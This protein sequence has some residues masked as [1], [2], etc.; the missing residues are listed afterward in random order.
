MTATPV[1][2]VKVLGK[3][4]VYGEANMV[5]VKVLDG[6]DKGQVRKRVVKGP[7][8]KGDV[9]MLLETERDHKGISSKRR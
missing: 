7:L 4:G 8:K 9:L 1:E 3:T 5:L 2:I 6:K